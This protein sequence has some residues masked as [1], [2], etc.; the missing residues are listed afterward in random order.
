MPTV[1]DLDDITVPDAKLLQAGLTHFGFY[2]GTMFGRPGP[3]TKDA[4]ARYTSASGPRG[5]EPPT[6]GALLTYPATV[7]RE[8]DFPG[9]IGQGA[10]GHKARRV[11]EWLTIH[12]QRTAID[13]DFGPATA[14]AVNAFQSAHGLTRTTGGEVDKP[15]WD[16]LVS[17]MIRAFGKISPASSYDVTVRAIAEQHLRE[18]PIELGGANCGPWV[19]AYMDGNQGRAWPWCAGFVTFV[20][21]QAAQ[22]QG[23][24]PPIKGS[25]SCDVLQR[26]AEQNGRFA[27]GRSIADLSTGGLGDCCVFLVRRTSSDWTHTGF[28]MDMDRSTFATIEGNT[29]DDGVREGYEVCKRV[30]GGSKIDFI[31]IA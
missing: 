30:R 11:Q 9:N 26:Q 7:M 6:P 5:G 20:L 15:T 8:L 22:I 10:T 28:A 12:G 29:N 21:K 17:P 14:R 31:K 23:G 3:K 24:S 2:S 1:I 18:H 25:F 16:E 4:Y 19:R 27:E 13:E